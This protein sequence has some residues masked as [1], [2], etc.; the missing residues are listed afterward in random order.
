MRN[1][2]AKMTG[3]DSAAVAGPPVARENHVAGGLTRGKLV[4]FMDEQRTPLVLFA[5]QPG[6]AAVPAASVVDLHE[7][8]VGRQVALM[9]EQAD[10]ARPVVM[11][12]L[13][14]EPGWPLDERPGQVE[15][16][17]DGERLIVS[18][19]EQLVLECGKASIT[20]TRAGKIVIHG[21]YVSSRSSGVMRI[22]GG[23]IQL[24]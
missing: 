19:R 24:N 22:K 6:T 10:P 8:H 1:T 17:A 3:T 16:V 18:A 11:G 13:R 15:V 4:G 20:L 12:V 2:K 23:S 5:G 14:G 9:F 7:A 21:T